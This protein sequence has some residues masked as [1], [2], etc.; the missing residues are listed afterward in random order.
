MAA[1]VKNG[2]D[3]STGRLLDFLRMKERYQ[4]ELDKITGAIAGNKRSSIYTSCQTP[5]VC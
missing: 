4:N 3:S 1:I 2:G 5:S